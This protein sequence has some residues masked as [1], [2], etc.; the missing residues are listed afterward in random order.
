MVST[1]VVLLEKW[2]DQVPALRSHLP[3]AMGKT[4]F[5]V[6]IWMIILMYRGMECLGSRVERR[7]IRTTD[8]ICGMT[9]HGCDASV[10]WNAADDLDVRVCV[11]CNPA[12]D[13]GARVSEEYEASQIF[14]RWMYLMT[15]ARRIDN[16]A[17]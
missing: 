16:D 12:T 4:R 10:P 6:D 7:Q 9:G 5:P 13:W 8:Q 11:R 2:N 17:G 14:E 1:M 15:E 3:G